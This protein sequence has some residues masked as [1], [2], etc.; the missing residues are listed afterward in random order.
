MCFL[1]RQAVTK[2]Q[3]YLIFRSGNSC[4]ARGLCGNLSLHILNIFFYLKKKYIR[5]KLI[6]KVNINK[7]VWR[8][9]ST[10]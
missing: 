8:G 3:A 1:T 9:S 7:G 5:H 4:R 2:V 6:F 10:S